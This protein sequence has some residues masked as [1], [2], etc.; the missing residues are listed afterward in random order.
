M[1]LRIVQSV[2]SLAEMQGGP[3]RTIVLLAEAQARAGADVHLVAR[4]EP[5]GAP[6]LRSDPA[7]APLTQVKGSADRRRVT[8]RLLDVPGRSILHDNGVWLSANRAAAA[9]ARRVR[10]P[11]VISP[12]GMLEPWAL[13]WNPG[14]KRLALALF[15]QRLLDTAAGLLATAEPER[16]NL[17]RL[18]KRTPIAVIANG[19]EMPAAVPPHNPAPDAPR[20]MLFLSRIHP[21]KNLP[22]LVD[23]WSMLMDRPEFG[24]WRLVIAGPDERGHRAE[25][26]LQIA[27]LGLASRI[28]LRGSVPDVRK[29]VLYAGSDL[30]ILPSSSENFG[31]VVAEAL[32]HGRP[33]ITTTGT[34]WSDLP[35]IGAGW[36][37]E[38]TAEALAGAMAE[39]M[40]LPP[41]AREAMGARGAALVAARHGWPLI[42][43]QTLE[44]Y[45]WL[46]EGG[47][48]PEFV[49][50]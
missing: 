4:T 6:L 16:A 18:V 46:L 29:S 34:P 28:E 2:D 36:W 38:P 1:S 25:L 41:A 37:T 30:F 13:A 9:S 42:A 19:V 24:H 5:D 44:F 47:P 49:D 10:R 3:S 27:G 31:I 26:A 8:A 35:A 45:R 39:A 40:L 15:Q 48:R 17:R 7:L 22:A 32:A 50:A 12:H 23:A 11:F 14:R 21:K 43:G 20:T 33:V